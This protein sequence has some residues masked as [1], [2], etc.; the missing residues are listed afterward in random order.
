MN[1][2]VKNLFTGLVIVTGVVGFMSGEYIISSALF[3]V[4]TYLSNINPGRNRSSN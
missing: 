2:L 3:A 1:G 4:T